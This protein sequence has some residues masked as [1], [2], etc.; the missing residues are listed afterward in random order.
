[1]EHLGRRIEPKK[2]DPAPEWKRDP[3]VKGLYRHR[4]PPHRMR[5]DPDAWEQAAAHL[6]HMTKGK[7]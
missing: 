4:D 1:M 5:Y 2:P 6:E 3:K 7:P